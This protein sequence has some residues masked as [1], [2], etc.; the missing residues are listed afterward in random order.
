MTDTIYTLMYIRA[1]PHTLAHTHRTHVQHIHIVVMCMRSENPVIML[2]AR[3]RTTVKVIRQI[4]IYAR[5]VYGTRVERLSEREQ[6]SAKRAD[7][8]N[9]TKHTRLN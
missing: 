1:L 6:S 9:H 7:T 5:I 8:E 2:N 4:E 3:V